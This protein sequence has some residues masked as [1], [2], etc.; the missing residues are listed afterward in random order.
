MKKNSHLGRYR[1]CLVLLLFA[2]GVAAPLQAAVARKDI[3]LK[4][5]VW[6]LS[7]KVTTSAG[8]AL[9]GVTVLLKGTTNGTAT[10]VDGSWQLSVPETSGTLI[11]SFIGYNTV[12]KNFNGPGT[13]NVALTVDAKTL[14][15][16][17]VTGYGTQAK[18]DL[19]GAVAVVD[20][21]D[22]L[23]VPAT[24]VAQ[25]LQG[26]V[27]G[28]NVGN[29]STPGGGV[30]VRIRG[31]GTIG[32]NDPL[33]VIDGVPTQGNLNTLNQNDIESIQ[34]LKDASSASIY[35]SRAANG[36][37]I[38]TTKKGKAGEPKLTFDAYYGTQRVGKRLDL[39]NSQELGTYIWQAER[40]SKGDQ[41]FN[42]SH[43]QYGNG[44]TPVIP[45]Y[46]FPSGAMEGDPRVD[47]SKYSYTPGGL[48]TRANKQGTKWMDE[49]FQVAPIQ[50]YNIGATGGTTSGRYALSLGYFN[51]K[52]TLK[53]VG[54][55]RYT[56]RANTEF[57]VKKRV[58]IGENLQVAYAQRK[59]GFGNQDEGNEISMAY[60]MHP[61]IPVYD[62][63]GNF[64]GGRGQNLGNA[65]NPVAM[66]YRNKDNLGRELRIFGNAYGEVDLFAG[67]TFRT[68]FG[69]DGN[70]N[71]GRYSNLPDIESVEANNNIELTVQERFNYS[72]TFTNTL[73]YNTVLGTDHKLDAYVGYEAIDAK[74]EFFGGYRRGYF[75]DVMALRYL[76]N[77]DQTTA[78]NENR[79]EVNYGL[80]ST[81]GKVNYAFEDKYLLQA[82]L[83]SDRSSRFLAA[84]NQAIF[85]AMSAGWRVSQEGF[86][87]DMPFVND[88]KLRAGWGKT[89]NQD[90]GDYN[91]YAT[92]RQSVFSNGY[93]IDGA[94]NSFALGFDNQSFANPK[95]KWET[96]SST[97][98]GL[99]LTLLN[100][101]MDFAFDW[102][103]RKTSDML[104]SSPLASTLGDA[105]IPAFNVGSMQNRGV[106][107]SLNYKSNAEN[108]VRYGLGFNLSTY[109]NLVLAL[110]E[111]EK[112]FYTGYGLRTPAVTRTEAGKPLSSFYGYIVDGIF[113]SEEEVKTYAK[114][115][116]YN[117]PGKFKYR[118]VNGDGEITTADQTYIG[119][120]HPDF[121]YGLNLNVG[122]KAFDLTLFG[123]GVQGNDIYNYVRYWT[124]FNTFQGN[125]SKRALYDAWQP[126]KTDAKITAPFA[127]DAISSR[128][129]TYFLEDGSYFRMKNIQLSYQM[130]QNLTSSIGMGSLQL[131][132]QGTNL[133][134]LTKYSGL[135]PDI[136]LR[137]YFAGDRNRQIGVDEGVYPV[138][139]N[140]IFGINVGF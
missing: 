11:F 132:V 50:N 69:L 24:N 98:L 95:A 54:Y 102:F 76:D 61:L 72:W 42:P 121:A 129:S 128:P 21:K 2:F 109:R 44:N 126:G 23:A 140:I 68:S 39:L 112:T 124:D 86:F 3:S 51:Q 103:N 8:D 90:I 130:P 53:H 34:V 110:D 131:Y 38:I 92:Y 123:A 78:S 17:V 52:G 135:D 83:R 81:F 14:E 56:V 75:S 41:S 80:V 134:T 104:F 32:N 125:R 30:M 60:R 66:L 1:S 58:R 111:N 27:S 20:T 16:V 99:D 114:F 62:I 63:K 119:S 46:I 106:E 10:A 26:R 88:L 36:V 70:V 84:S 4:A 107:F 33:F 29:E 65:K 43:G 97:N 113:Q 28:V 19:T 105:N 101:Q 108:I 82:I 136:N 18:K 100:S 48:I 138:S 74:Q 71:R 64:A 137:N 116:G 25:Q 37:V 35:G 5:V 115:E 127:N 31:F 93:S 139:K 7:G 77:G 85:P 79:L 22:L 94:P 133:F 15:E 55:D 118:D 6:Q 87:A 67:L 120:P 40:N 47:P 59:G 117:A 73:A 91:A 57:T 122:Y 13:I 89:G 96:T 9:P 49:I 45:D 12:E